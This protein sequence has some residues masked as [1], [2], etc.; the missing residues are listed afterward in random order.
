[1]QN[2]DL[3]KWI[4]KNNYTIK[5]AITFCLE[6]ARGMSFLVAKNIIHGDLACRNIML[7]ESMNLKIADFGLSH[8]TT[9]GS[10]SDEDVYYQITNLTN[11]PIRWYPVD[12]LITCMDGRDTK[13]VLSSSDMWS[14]GIVM[15][16]I[17]GKGISPYMK[18]NNAWIAQRVIEGHR[19]A[20]LPDCPQA[21][22]ELMLR[23]W[24]KQHRNRPS[25]DDIIFALGGFY[26]GAGGLGS[27]FWKDAKSCLNHG[28]RNPVELDEEKANLEKTVMIYEN[29]VFY[30]R[31]KSIEKQIVKHYD[32]IFP[33]GMDLAWVNEK[34]SENENSEK[35]S[36]RRYCL[37]ETAKRDTVKAEFDDIKLNSYVQ[38][39][40][41]FS[42]TGFRYNGTRPERILQAT[43]R[44]DISHI[45]TIFETY[46]D[47]NTEAH[48]GTGRFCKGVTKMT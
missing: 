28:I 33:N 36:N 44:Q 37:L 25:F 20:R 11:I 17:F 8:A 29:D 45:E 27:M 24:M 1:M 10:V 22:Y 35:T 46:P 38:S 4:E 40:N 42:A 2:G 23:T 31:D 14:F 15:H 48:S 13:L 16:E 30:E 5:Q 34:M 18:K 9:G 39:E 21:V 47:T 26:L 6:T 43:K 12:M 7:D 19:L 32:C 3:K 41:E